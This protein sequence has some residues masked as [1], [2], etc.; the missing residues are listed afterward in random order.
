MLLYTL[1]IGESV[2]LWLEMKLSFSCFSSPGL[3]GI[4]FA[5]SNL[6]FLSYALSLAAGERVARGDEMIPGDTGLNIM[7]RSNAA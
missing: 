3:Y 2:L 7:S 6:F 5:S 1:L 4:E